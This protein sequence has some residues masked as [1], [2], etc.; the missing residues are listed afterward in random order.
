MRERGWKVKKLTCWQVESSNVYRFDISWS[1]KPSGGVTIESSFGSIRA[2]MYWFKESSGESS[3]RKAPS[4]AW[5]SALR[6]ASSAFKRP[7][8]ILELFSGAAVSRTW[9]Q[10][11]RGENQQK[12]RISPETPVKQE[13]GWIFLLLYNYHT[14]DFNTN[15]K[16]TE[17]SW[18]NSNPS[19]ILA[20]SS[21]TS[22]AP[23]FPALANSMRCRH[24][25]TRAL[26]RYGFNHQ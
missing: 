7:S 2:L 24:S 12:Q 3:S 11:K 1:N 26:K 14:S 5:S 4:W 15:Q 19:E 23:D 25:T 20:L 21:E 18:R 22:S 8:M 9:E 13:R 6:L 10:R 17:R 16:L